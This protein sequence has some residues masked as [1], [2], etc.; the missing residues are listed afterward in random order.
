M[1]GNDVGYKLT[2][3]KLWRTVI[4]SWYQCGLYQMYLESREFGLWREIKQGS[5]QLP[6]ATRCHGGQVGQICST[7]E[8]RPGVISTS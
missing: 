3:C 1:C 7:K 4:T 5:K 2:R 6:L 8:N